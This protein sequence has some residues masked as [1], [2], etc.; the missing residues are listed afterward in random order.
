MTITLL[1][2]RGEFLRPVFLSVNAVQSIVLV[3]STSWNKCWTSK[4]KTGFVAN[5]YTTKTSSINVWGYFWWLFKMSFRA[6]KASVQ[7]T[8]VC[9]MIMPIFSIE[10]KNNRWLP[11]SDT[12]TWEVVDQCFGICTE[13]FFKL[14]I[15]NKV[16]Q[17][18][19]TFKHYYSV[20]F[21]WTPP[22]Y[23]ITATGSRVVYIVRHPY[24]LVC[25]ITHVLFATARALVDIVTIF[26]N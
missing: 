26:Y 9:I 16:L 5:F 23:L 4:Y 24:C 13:K 11:Y 6:C 3:R 14:F 1:Q 7:H 21:T 10:H 18:N 12:A 22:C 25:C 20:Q 2:S 19:Y 15:L 17:D 8:E